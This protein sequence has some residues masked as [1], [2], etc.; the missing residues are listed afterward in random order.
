MSWTSGRR[1]HSR[2]LDDGSCRPPSWYREEGASGRVD[3][4]DAKPATSLYC[5][6]R[7]TGHCYTEEPMTTLQEFRCEVCGIVTSNP[8]HWFVIRCG[9]SELTVHRWNSE[10]AEAAGARHYCGEAHAE[11]YISRWFDSVCAPPKPS[12]K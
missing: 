12:F 2:A 4:A 5:D 1:N 10:A 6:I 3:G 7:A 11:V 9:D 8:I